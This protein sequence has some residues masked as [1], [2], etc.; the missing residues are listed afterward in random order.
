MLSAA[1]MLG[2]PV[3]RT[4]RGPEVNV[5]ERAI[6]HVGGRPI[7]LARRLSEIVG[8]EIVR[9]VLHGWRLRGVFPR[10]M[11]MPVHQLTGIPLDQLLAA[12][13]R[14]KEGSIVEEAIER[15]GGTA[16]A[17]AEALTK[18]SGRKCTRQMVANWLVRGQFPRQWVLDVHLLT[19]IPV[20]RL[21]E[22]TTA[23]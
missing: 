22:K 2:G 14:R 17:F 12:E 8:K 20:P 3:R 18:S 23:K 13:V 1:V 7:D 21:M 9:Q 11:M 19:K 15:D 10:D 16:A 4:R 6:A 5:V